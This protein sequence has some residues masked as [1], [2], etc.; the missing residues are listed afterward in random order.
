MELSIFITFIS[1][2]KHKGSRYNAVERQLE[3]QP[4][5]TY[6][7]YSHAMQRLVQSKINQK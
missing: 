1:T 3:Q 5:T 6:F 2:A 4:P 7:D